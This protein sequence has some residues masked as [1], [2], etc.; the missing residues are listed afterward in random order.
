MAEGRTPPHQP[1]RRTRQTSSLGDCFLAAGQL[2]A[3]IADSFLAAGIIAD[4]AM[5]P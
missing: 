4:P 5:F 2:A 1:V 3:I